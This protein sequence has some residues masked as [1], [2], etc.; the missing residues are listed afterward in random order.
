MFS[1]VPPWLC[2]FTSQCTRVPSIGISLGLSLSDLHS[3][4]MLF[5][6][7]LMV[8]LFASAV[9]QTRCPR[10]CAARSRHALRRACHHDQAGLLTPVPCKAM[11]LL[12]AVQNSHP[13]AMSTA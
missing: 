7:Y 9:T 12:F 4:G 8:D 1:S 10:L 2:K 13:L 3:L 11:P 5:N 6:V